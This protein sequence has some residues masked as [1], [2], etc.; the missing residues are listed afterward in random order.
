MLYNGVQEF[1]KIEHP[2][3]YK[4]MLEAPLDSS[5]G[6][7]RD[8]AA[9]EVPNK[10]VPEPQKITVSSLYLVSEG[11]CMDSV[12][13]KIFREESSF[14]KRRP[15]LEFMSAYFEILILRKL[16]LL[17]SFFDLGSHST[18][19]SKLTR[20]F[21]SYLALFSSSKSSLDFSPSDAFLGGISP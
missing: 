13:N 20:S 7:W 6:Q 19:S 2:Q 21:F 16:E 12:V 8:I 17:S 11:F 3:L 4:V 14:H 9:R 5:F 10:D 18:T 15:R 1:L